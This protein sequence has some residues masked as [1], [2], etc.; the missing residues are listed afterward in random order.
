[1]AFLE[2]R[3]RNCTVPAA[4]HLHIFRLMHQCKYLLRNGEMF[5]SLNRS[6]IQKTQIDR[7]FEKYVDAN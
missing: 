6:Y 2:Y 3:Q 4:S 1:M 7:E 5:I